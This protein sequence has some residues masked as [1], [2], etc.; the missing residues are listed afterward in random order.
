MWSD[1]VVRGVE[2]QA[3]GRCVGRGN[4]KELALASTGFPLRDL[5]PILN[6]RVKDIAWTTPLLETSKVVMS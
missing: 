5:F 2:N 6:C 1:P 3:Y 4:T